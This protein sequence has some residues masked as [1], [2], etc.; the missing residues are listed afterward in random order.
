[1][2]KKLPNVKIEGFTIDTLMAPP[3][4]WL[5]PNV[6]IRKVDSFTTEVSKDDLQSY[7]IVRVA[8]LAKHIEDNNPGPV[9][10]NVLAMLKPGGYVQWDELDTA[11]YGIVRLDPTI[12]APRLHALL[13]RV[14]DHQH[15]LGPRGW[16]DS[17]PDI[18]ARYGLQIQ[19]G[20]H[21]HRLP[22]AYAKAENDS[23][24]A[25]FEALSYR[26]EDQ[27]DRQELRQLMT[28]ARE[29][30]EQLGQA[31]MVDLVVAVGRKVY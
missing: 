9:I 5:P 2:A 21:R 12:P 14:H 31:V 15:A 25:E 30:C 4:H 27:Q 18:L 22:F 13:K 29:D 11:H 7:D 28:A 6:A 16:I 8:N 1:M 23:C 10:K 19:P 17:L 24:F 26:L 3:A 20:Q